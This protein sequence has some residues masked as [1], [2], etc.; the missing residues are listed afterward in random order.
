MT[1]GLIY[2]QASVNCVS[3]TCLGMPLTLA[4]DTLVPS[5]SFWCEMAHQVALV[6]GVD[7]L[8]QRQDR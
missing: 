8:H 5:T 7:I 4:R 6:A 1:G 2:D 3:P